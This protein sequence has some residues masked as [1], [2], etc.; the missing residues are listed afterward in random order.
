MRKE[1][2]K[3][4]IGKRPFDAKIMGGEY[5]LLDI[6]EDVNSAYNTKN[7]YKK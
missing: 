4:F 3:S 7:S 5:S 1:E 6:P 2:L